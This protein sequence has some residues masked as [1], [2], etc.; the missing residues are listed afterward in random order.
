MSANNSV[1][2]H[3]KF[4]IALQSIVAIVC[5]VT[6]GLF[7]IAL[8]KKRSL[9]SPSNTLL[10]ILSTIDFLTG[11]IAMPMWIA[12]ATNT[13]CINCRPFELQWGTI[14]TWIFCSLSFQFIT[15]ISLDRYAAICHPYRYL[16]VAS[17]SLFLRISGCACVLLIAVSAPI[18]FTNRHEGNAIY[19]LCSNVLACAI[20]GILSFSNIRIFMVIK[21]QRNEVVSVN[22][23]NR[24]QIQRREKERKRS[25]LVLAIIAVSCVCMLPYMIT[26]NLIQSANFRANIGSYA[27]IAS[28]EAWV[29]FLVFMNSAMN[30]VIYYFRVSY[31]RDA[32]RE[33]IAC[34]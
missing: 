19:V 22:D 4:Y 31:F 5:I 14:F 17:S 32:V 20:V 12:R 3:L 25:Y 28:I 18:L 13:F 2:L 7:V 16:Q 21:R 23:E 9:H 33:M 29:I 30:P 26:L 6:N 34:T 24:T 11:L 8:I 1:A 27:D 10:G 15:L